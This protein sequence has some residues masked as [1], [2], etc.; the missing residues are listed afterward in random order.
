VVQRP[1]SNRSVTRVRGQRRTVSSV[2]RCTRRSRDDL[3]VYVFLLKMAAGRRDI[4]SSRARGR[5]WPRV[6]AARDFS[7]VG[8]HRVDEPETIRLYRVARHDADAITAVRPAAVHP[9]VLLSTRSRPPLARGDTRASDAVFGRRRKRTPN[10]HGLR[11]NDRRPPRRVRTWGNRKPPALTSYVAAGRVR[12]E[13]QKAR[14]RRNTPG[15]DRTRRSCVTSH[16]HARTRRN[17]RAV[18]PAAARHTDYRFGNASAPKRS[19]NYVR[20]QDGACKRINP[21]TLH[22]GYR[23]CDDRSCSPISRHEKLA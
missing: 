15:G 3:R 6:R 20:R 9:S 13:R 23:V 22:T 5:R 16:T 2:R 7:I 12:T 17:V 11:P 18:I 10:E 4:P 21:S 1:L 19:R 8:A 14:A